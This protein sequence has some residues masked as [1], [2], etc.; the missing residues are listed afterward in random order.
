VDVLARWLPG[1]QTHALADQIR[2]V[3]V[4]IP[5]SVAGGHARR[6]TKELLHHLSIAR[7]SLAGLPTLFLRAE[8]RGCRHEAEVEEVEQQALDTQMPLSRPS[9][10]LRVKP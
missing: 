7:E 3:A 1:G 8:R 10:S 6:H 4:S 2:R 9:S 5:P